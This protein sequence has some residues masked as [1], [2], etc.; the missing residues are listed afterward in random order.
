MNMRLVFDPG[1]LERGKLGQA[2]V[3]EPGRIPAISGEIDRPCTNYNVHQMAVFA[4]GELTGRPSVSGFG[5]S[6]TR[7]IP[8][9]FLTP[10]TNLDN[11]FNIPATERTRWC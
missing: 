6:L 9:A 8:L 2:L 3:E 5:F 11:D 10:T 7:C 4:R 1:G